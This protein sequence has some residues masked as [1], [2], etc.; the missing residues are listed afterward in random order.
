M[1][2]I[3]TYVYVNATT[4]PNSSK[5]PFCHQI[6]DGGNK[7]VQDDLRAIQNDSL[8]N[9]LQI[10]GMS[11]LSMYKVHFMNVQI[12]GGQGTMPSSGF[13]SAYTVCFPVLPNPCTESEKYCMINQQPE[14]RMKYHQSYITLSSTLGEIPS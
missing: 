1:M 11:L 14:N 3:P 6:S 4:H 12:Q 7:M 10:V 9:L 2:C 5:C 13:A 8:F